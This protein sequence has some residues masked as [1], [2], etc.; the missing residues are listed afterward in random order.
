[1]KTT[2]TLI[3]AAVALLPAMTQA[4]SAGVVPV[5]AAVRALQGCWQGDGVVLGKPVTIALRAA[6]L[7]LDSMVVIDADSAAKADATDR[8]QA[9]LLFGGTDAGPGGRGKAISSFWA[10][11]FGGSFTATGTGDAR[12]D[13]FE[14]DYRYPDANFVNR[15]RLQEGKLSW[16][17]VSKNA[18][19]EKPFARY[20][21]KPAPCT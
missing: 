12:D 8:Y 16:T 13:G 19:G 10:D 21:L 1:M 18:A 20:D 6:P 2:T 4:Q 17:I 3:A 15:W 7:L 5:P 14:V 11:S 9:H